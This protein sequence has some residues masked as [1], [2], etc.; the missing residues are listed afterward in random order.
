MRLKEAQLRQGLTPLKM[1]SGRALA[2][3]TLNAR[4]RL[5][6][7]LP[8]YVPR[9]QC[10]TTD[11]D[12][13]HGAGRTEHEC[14][15]CVCQSKGD[16]SA[17]DAQGTTHHE[18]EWKP[19]RPMGVVQWPHKLPRELGQAKDANSCVGSANGDSDDLVEPHCST[20]G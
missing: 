5:C 6:G 11:R 9:P 8:R 18:G 16:E 4:G 12:I 17:S 20:I 2:R 15:P 7:C 1:T 10:P 19:P 3:L 14:D 13:A